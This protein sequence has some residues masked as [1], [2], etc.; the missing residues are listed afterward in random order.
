MID[1]ID[2]IER[3]KTAV[4]GIAYSDKF[5]KEIKEII[6]R[7]SKNVEDKEEEKFSK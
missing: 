6:K 3:I 7:I 4:A 2:E 1:L 5:E